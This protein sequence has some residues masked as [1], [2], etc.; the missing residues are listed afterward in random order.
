MSYASFQAPR[1]SYILDLM[2][3]AAFNIVSFM[4]VFHVKINVENIQQYLFSCQFKHLQ[5]IL[6]ETMIFLSLT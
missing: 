1:G 6:H 3:S 5:N 2:F 4:G